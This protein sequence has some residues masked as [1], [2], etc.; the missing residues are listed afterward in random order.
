MVAEDAV[1]Y[2]HSDRTAA[3]GCQRCDRAI[4]S[5]CMHSA[6]VGFHCPECTKTGAQK[7]YRA[8]DLKSVPRL[9]YALMA[10]NVAAFVA[11]GLSG[12]GQGF[13]IGRVAQEGIL[14][15]PLVAQGEVW[16]IIT[17]GFLHG[18]ILHVAMNMYALYV[19][20]PNLETGVGALR[21]GL[22]YAGGLLGG[23]AA[24]L[25]FNYE[26]PT[27]GASGAVLG[28]AGGLA[29]VLWSRGIAITQTSLGGLFL[30]N[31]ALPILVPRISFWGHLGG[32]AGGFIVGWLVSW[33]PAKFGQSTAVANA[34]GAGAVVVMAAVGL[35]GARAGGLL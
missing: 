31:L 24:V 23:S 29:A 3:V 32:I 28:L 19:F 8:K 35:V 5:S 13:T 34:A 15:G 33:L 7:V 26:Q 9:V 6:S 12:Q 1:C 4:C 27:L 17:G 18:S 10:I 20:G 21:T 22:I 2:R 14:W 16:R 30:I 25:L 11:Q